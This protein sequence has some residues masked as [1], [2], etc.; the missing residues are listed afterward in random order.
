MAD[1]NEEN[2]RDHYEKS[3]NGWN[4]KQKEKEFRHETARILFVY[5]SPAS[6]GDQVP[7]PIA[8]VHFRFEM[9]DEQKHP[10]V[11]CYEI[12]VKREFQSNGLGKHLMD[13]LYQIG[14]RFKMHKVMLTCFKHNTIA[15]D[16]YNKLGYTPDVRSPEKCG[17][18]A[19]Y[20]IL[21]LRIRSK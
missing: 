15:L 11:Y 2:M 6:A 8:F 20:Q 5:Q 12:M 18:T 10:A 3:E 1:L 7:E 16:W 14:Y 19:S 4:K 17:M 9:D 21:C 13:V